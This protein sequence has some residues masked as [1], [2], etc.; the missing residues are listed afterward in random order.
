MKN[1][2]FLITLLFQVLNI[3]AQKNNYT[4]CSVANT[5]NELVTDGRQI[6]YAL[7]KNVISIKIEIEKITNYK[8]PYSEYAQKY[9][10]INKNVILDNFNKYT[11]KSVVFN[12]E[13]KIDTN[14]YYCIK[15]ENGNFPILQFSNNGTLLSCNSLM[16]INDSF[17]EDGTP[18]VTINKENTTIAFTD[19]G[20]KPFLNEVDKVLYKTVETDSTPQQIEYKKK[21]LEPTTEEQNAEEAAAL[22]RKIRKR[23]LKLMMGLKDE[24]I[25]TDDDAI[26]IM[27]NKLEEYEQKYLELFMGKSVKNTETYYFEFNPNNKNK[28]EHI[29]LGWLSESSGFTLK[30]SN[31]YKSLSPIIVKSVPLN[32]VPQV[33]VKQKDYTQKTP[34][35]IKYGLYYRIPGTI[36]LSAYYKDKRI[37]VQQISIAQKGEVIP[38]PV[39]YLNN[40]YS[41]EFYPQTGALK[42]I[43]LNK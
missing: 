23:K 38:L 19:L 24:V 1:I 31:K 40:K 6:F 29:I 35:D 34:I 25:T 30:K 33:E 27:I 21:I 28:E 4:N 22:I 17:Y 5:G 9:L 8:G 15:V 39:E 16:R 11:I 26:K 10:N 7:P 41:I 43:Y 2:L 20:V 12:R 36:S 37:L 42:G 14:Q 13:S 18:K 3:F 32:K